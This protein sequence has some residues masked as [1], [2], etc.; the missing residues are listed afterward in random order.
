MPKKE[1]TDY[2]IY[3]IICNDENI[4]D[5]YV[6]STSNFKVRKWQHKICCDK[7]NYKIYKIIN[8][9]GGWT[10]WS[11]IPIAEYKELTLTQSR[12]KEEEHRLNLK[13]NMN[14]I[15]AHINDE[16]TKEYKH[17]FY[18][19]NKQNRLEIEKKYRQENKELIKERN[20]K[21][22]QENIDI[23]KEKSKKWREQ[24]K[25]QKAQVDK[26]YY[27]KN[28]EKIIAQRMVR[29]WKTNELNKKD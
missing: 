13:A 28:K 1:I 3:K 6:G 12:I 9:N 18:E 26:S 2:V 14:S 29:Y 21:W 20:K 23:I 4:K 25:Q 19:K 11:M 8:E 7:D 15:K 27:E 24:N 22:R 17:Q 10:N 5:C 16:E